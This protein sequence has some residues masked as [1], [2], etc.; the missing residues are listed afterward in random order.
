MKT[1]RTHN[2]STAQKQ[3]IQLPEDFQFLGA[4]YDSPNLVIS[5]LADYEKA[6]H[7]HEL[8]IALPYQHTDIF[9]FKFLAMVN[10]PFN[11]YH[12]YLNP[13]PL[14]APSNSPA[15]PPSS[16]SSSPLTPTPSPDPS[17][18]RSSTT[19]PSSSS[20]PPSPSSPT[21]TTPPSSSTQTRNP[22]NRP[23]Q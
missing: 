9:S 21:P 7:I 1:I 15:S 17:P 12:L 3:M 20:S 16:P 13:K 5:V 14:L 2:I 8:Y 18:V 4:Y 22:S 6:K 11:T 19:S 10:T 23:P